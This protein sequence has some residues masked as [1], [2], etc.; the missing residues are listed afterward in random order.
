MRAAFARVG[1]PVTALLWVGG[2][3]ILWCVARMLWAPVE[4]FRAYLP[5]W[6]F[7]TGIPLGA[8]AW[9]M[10]HGLTGGAWGCFVRPALMA[11][12]AVLPLNALLGVPL[13]FGLPN[14]FPWAMPGWRPETASGGQ[15][16]YLSPGFFLAREV[17]LFALWLGLAAWLGVWRR[18]PLAAIPPGRCAAGLILYGLGITVFAIDWT[19]SLEPGWFTENVGFLA[20]VEALLAGLAFGTAAMCVLARAGSLGD[21]APRFHDLGG[22]LLALLLL[23]TYL[24][25]EQYLTVWSGNL[26]DKAEWY[27]RRNAGAWRGW[28]WLMACV[29]GALPFCLL[30]SRNLKRDPGRLIWAAGWVLA[31]NLLGQ[32]WLVLPAFYAGPEGVDGL[33]FLPFIGIGGLWLAVF[34]WRLPMYLDRQARE[35]TSDG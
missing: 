18:M 13:L 12:A 17:A 28:A 8:M 33:G 6:L 34:L 4:L 2:L 31:G 14:L 29:Y 16:I 22:L 1:R 10:I 35:G 9:L 7:W 32:Y 15:A 19:M 20:G 3:A 27:L 26:P 11:A 21:A 23:W 24:A 30:L 5:A 25:F